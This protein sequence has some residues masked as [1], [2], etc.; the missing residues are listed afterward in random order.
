MSKKVS[1]KKVV[2]TLSLADNGF[3]PDRYWV[4]EVKA[5]KG[6]V[7][8]FVSMKDAKTWVA[9]QT[10]MNKMLRTAAKAIAAK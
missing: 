9:A 2:R 5:A 4:Y 10:K 7:K 6:V 8:R 1:I 3:V